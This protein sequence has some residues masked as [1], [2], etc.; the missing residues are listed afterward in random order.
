MYDTVLS[1][2]HKYD[3][4]QMRKFRAT[5]STVSCSQVISSSLHWLVTRRGRAPFTPEEGAQL[6]LA[7]TTLRTELDLTHPV[8]VLNYIGKSPFFP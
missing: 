6:L 7:Q 8:S 1:T 2:G 4:W 5:D 3:L